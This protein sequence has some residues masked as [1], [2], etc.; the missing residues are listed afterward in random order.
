MRRTVRAV[1]IARPVQ[2]YAIRMAMATHPRPPYAHRLTTDSSA[3]A[4]VR[5][6][7]RHS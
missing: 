3:T 5:A 4:R 1:P 2:D 7:R 6:A